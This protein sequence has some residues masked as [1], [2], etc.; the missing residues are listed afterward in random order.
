MSLSVSNPLWSVRR[1][2]SRSMAMRCWLL[3]VFSGF[4][5]FNVV[6]VSEFFFLSVWFCGV[7]VKQQGGFGVCS[8]VISLYAGLYCPVRGFMGVVV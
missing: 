5:S 3:V 4:T 7:F 2:P 6:M 8:F 1:V